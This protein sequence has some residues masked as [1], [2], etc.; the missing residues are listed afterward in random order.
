M[1][2]HLGQNVIIS[3]R[4]I[5]GI[6]DLDNTTSAADTRDFLRLAEKNGKVINV[7]EELPK[8]FVVW[9][10]DGEKRVYISQMSSSTL[11]KRSEER[12]RL[13]GGDD[14]EI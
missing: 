9:Q 7:S 2:L 1:Y 13:F 4:D 11:L 5:V 10:R 12:R 14:F 8:S 6:F 3:T